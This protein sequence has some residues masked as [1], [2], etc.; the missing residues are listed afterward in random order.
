MENHGLLDS[1]CVIQIAYQAIVQNCPDFAFA[2]KS[3]YAPICG[4]GALNV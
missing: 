2:R 4:T 3:A 1:R